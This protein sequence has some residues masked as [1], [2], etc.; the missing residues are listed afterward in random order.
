MK[1]LD[2]MKKSKAPEKKTEREKLEERREEVLAK[3][4]KFKYPLQYAKHKMIINTLVLAGLALVLSLVLGWFALYKMQSTSDVAYRVMQVL[5]LPVAEVDGE[6]VRYGDYLLVYRS[7]V[8]PVEQQGQ[9]GAKDE[10]R[11]I[12]ETYKRTALDA[13]EEYTFAKKIA[14]E[15]GIEV[16]DKMLDEAEKVHLSAGGVKKSKEVFLK[17]LKDNFGLS[18]R[19]YRKLLKISLMK[20]EVS[21]KIDQKAKAL[22]DEVAGKVAASADLSAVAKEIGGAVMYEETGGLVDKMNIDGGRADKAMKL[23]VGA[24]SEAFLSTNGDG[25]YIVKTIGKTETQI[26]YVSVFSPFSELKKR[27]KSLRKAGKIKE[28]IKLEDKR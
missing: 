14:R 17:I 13:V 4:R 23:E 28:H 16:T 12:R 7:S 22:I 21:K 11:A 15:K 27:V 25:Y 26:N 19:E 9:E 3:G 5:P 18:E 2:K 1:I 10:I 20:T 6:G 8:A 24:A